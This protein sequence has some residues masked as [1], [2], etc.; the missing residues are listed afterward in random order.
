M[1]LYN[2]PQS[3]KELPC[4]KLLLAIQQSDSMSVTTLLGSLAV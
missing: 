4:F 2:D 3:A 1:G